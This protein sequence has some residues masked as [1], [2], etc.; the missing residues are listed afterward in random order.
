MNPVTENEIM[1][2]TIAIE[3]KSEPEN[4]TTQATTKDAIATAMEENIEVK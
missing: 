4:G 3:M 2:T 1:Q